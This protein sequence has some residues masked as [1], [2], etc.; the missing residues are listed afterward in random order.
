MCPSDYRRWA[1]WKRDFIFVFIPGTKA[2]VD[3]YLAEAR[4]TLRREEKLLGSELEIEQ[5]TE[6]RTMDQIK[7]AAIVEAIEANNYNVTEAGRELQVSKATMY[8]AIQKYGIK[9][10]RS[11]ELTKQGRPGHERGSS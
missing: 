6:A 8:R 10:K 9:V 1:N 3:E 7:A 4:T 11:I 5:R 2:V